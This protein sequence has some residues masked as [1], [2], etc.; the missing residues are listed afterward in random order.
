MPRPGYA[1]LM[2]RE[3][4]QSW[5]RRLHL[6]LP[7]DVHAPAEARRALRALPLGA[8]A[9]DVLLLASELVASAV[10]H[11]GHSP[12]EPIEL[13]AACKPGCTRVEVR[14]HGSGLAAGEQA[15]GLGLHVLA[16]AS[17]RWGI[18]H[19]GLTRI[20]FELDQ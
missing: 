2:H 6:M 9:D 20:W 18:E 11:A 12:D 3:E 17:E 13:T 8:R 5:A 14:D 4:A 1:D 10:A 19:D 7:P 15:G 16:A